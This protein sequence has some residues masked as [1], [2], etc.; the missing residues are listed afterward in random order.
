M[1]G[2]ESAAIKKGASRNGDAD[3]ENGLVD[4]V[5]E[6]EAGTHRESLTDAYKLSNVKQI[7]NRK[8]L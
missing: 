6:G 3:M 8:L 5:E 1:K 7:T 2:R 4:P